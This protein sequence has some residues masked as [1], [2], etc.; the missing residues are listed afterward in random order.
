M[1]DFF[2]RLRVRRSVLK[3]TTKRKDL[4]PAVLYLEWLSGE[5]SRRVMGP[6]GQAHVFT[7]DLL[8][9][10]FKLVSN[11]EAQRLIEAH[12]QKEIA[13]TQEPVRKEG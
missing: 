5:N 7:D 11:T 1:A 8:Q 12:W 3:R 6:D 2:S 9:S 10:H 13:P 4:P